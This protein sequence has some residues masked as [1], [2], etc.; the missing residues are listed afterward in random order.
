MDFV[1]VLTL[2]LSPVRSLHF[3]DDSNASR[4]LACAQRGQPPKY[5][6]CVVVLT[7]HLSPVGSLHF[8]DDSDA[9]RRLARAQRGQPP[10]YMA[11]AAC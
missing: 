11:F 7:L 9:S 6:D 2:N 8:Q 10:K 3:Q 4:R 1:V 5:M